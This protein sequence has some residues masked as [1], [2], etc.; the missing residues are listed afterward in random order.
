MAA[1]MRIRRGKTSDKAIGSPING[2]CTWWPPEVCLQLCT[3]A[4]IMASHLN[5]VL[6]Q[7]FTAYP[8]FSRRWK[9]ANNQERPGRS[10]PRWEQTPVADED[11]HPGPRWTAPLRDVLLPMVYLYRGEFVIEWDIATLLLNRSS[12]WSAIGLSKE[13]SLMILQFVTDHHIG[14]KQ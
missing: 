6:Y 9:R 2:N 12:S 7:Q 3:F 11:T 4:W 14:S 5:F 10:T 8:K 13:L 1:K